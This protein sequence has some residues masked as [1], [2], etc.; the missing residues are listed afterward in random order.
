MTAEL[1]P[2]IPVKYAL[3]KN[4]NISSVPASNGIDAPLLVITV[5]FA[6]APA[7]VFPIPKKTVTEPAFK[8]RYWLEPRE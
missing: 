2:V 4:D 8:M 5:A 3:G 6:V 7:A 1:E